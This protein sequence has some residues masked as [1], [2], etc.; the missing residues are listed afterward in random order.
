LTSVD[1]RERQRALGERLHA[2]RRGRQLSRRE[3]AAG[4]GV[5]ASFLGMVERGET[6]VALARFLRLADFFGVSI[7]ELLEQ[8]GQVEPPAIERFA[9]ADAAERGAGVDYRILRRRDPQLIAVTL[10][11]G[12]RFSDLRSH[13]GEDVW[14]VLAGRPTFLYGS[15]RYPVEEGH[16]V[17]F[18]G[19]VEHGL[20]NDGEAPARLVAVCSVPYW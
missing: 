19:S 5:S 6:D 1:D 16:V 14:L 2:L 11:P 4:V 18:A 13:R 17:T 7:A 12:A 3:V 10:E 15:R 9:D 20:A 8:D